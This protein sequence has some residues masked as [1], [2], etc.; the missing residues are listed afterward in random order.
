LKVTNKGRIAKGNLGSPDPAQSA[1]T[2]SEA[3]IER[4]VRALE[5]AGWRNHSP[6]D[7]VVSVREIFTSRPQP[8]RGEVIA[9]HEITPPMDEADEARHE[10][11]S[12]K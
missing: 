10:K 9:A 11:P 4:I 2:P 12:I 5:R 1:D 7:S 3:E 8:A 6:V